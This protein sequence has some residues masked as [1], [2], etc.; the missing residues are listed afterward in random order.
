MININDIVLDFTNEEQQRFINYLE[1][2]NKRNDFKNVQLFKLL[3]K[4]EL[5]SKEICFKLYKSNKQNAYHALRKRL[6]QSLIEFIAN[7]NLK[8]D[9]SID[10]Q[11]IKYILASRT[12]LQQGQYSVA[13]NILNKA[14]ALAN[15]HYLFTLLSEIYHTQIQYSYSFKELDIDNLILKFQENQ[16]NHHLENQLNIVYAKIRQTLNDISFE[17]EVVDFQIS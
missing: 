1:L 16:K 8:E 6:Y 12:F 17:G 3:V 14:E 11:I 10:M 4:N 7:V 15:E 5:S 13:Y 2:K 9:N